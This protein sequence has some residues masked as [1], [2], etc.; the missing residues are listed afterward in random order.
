VL[1]CLTALLLA[2]A[3]T[4][5]YSNPPT[6]ITNVVV[7]WDFVRHKAD[8]TT[9]VYDAP[10]SQIAT[11]TCPD[12]SS[13]C[14]PCAQSG[15]DFVVLTQ[16]DGTLVDPDRPS[17]SC[18]YNGLHGATALQVPIGPQTFRV[19][20][21]RWLAGGASVALYAGEVTIDVIAG[22][23]I[24]TTVHAAGIRQD[25]A[26]GVTFANAAGSPIGNT[27]PAGE[28]S[29]LHRLVDSAGTVV[30]E[31]PMLC[32]PAGISYLGSQGIDRD[33][34]T[35][36]VQAFPSASPAPGDL[37]D[38]DSAST[39]APPGQPACSQQPFD[40]YADDTGASAWPATAYDVTANA[41]RCP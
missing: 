7:Y 37:P 25:L 38:Y 22:V 11:G 29:L 15:V 36:R 4:G 19:T 34:Y 5:C 40:H 41:S 21:Y 39:A 23:Y 33:R 6:P 30:A 35:I 8:G 12:G 18:T 16:G 20:G 1:G 3:G 28:L 32:S 26:V 9:V 24:E 14:G 10:L 2:V 27:C 31:G 13:G 17:M